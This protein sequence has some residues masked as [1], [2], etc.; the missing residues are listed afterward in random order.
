MKHRT[1][2]I[3]FIA[4]TIAA[5]AQQPQPDDAQAQQ[6]AAPNQQQ[7]PGAQQDGAEPSQQQPG[8]F[9]RR[10][11]APVDWNHN[12]EVYPNTVQQP[13]NGDPTIGKRN[14]DSAPRPSA[15]E[16]AT[17]AVNPS[18]T[19]YGGLLSQWHQQLV[20]D[21]LMSVEF[22]GLVCSL[23][24]ILFL[25]LY[26]LW[27]Q[28]QRDQRLQVTV[29]LVLQLTNSRNFARYHNLRVI[30]IHNDLVE[31]LNDQ[32]ERELREDGGAPRE[33]D[34]AT[35]PASSSLAPSG[36]DIDSTPQQQP[37]TSGSEQSQEVSSIPSVAAASE[38]GIEG[39]SQFR[40]AGFKKKS[41]VVDNGGAPTAQSD[42][43][44]ALARANAAAVGEQPAA[45]TDA[46]GEESLEVKNRRLEAQVQALQQRTTSLRN[47]LNQQRQA[48]AVGG[49][50]NSGEPQ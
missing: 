2:G 13:D 41:P 19:N 15:V 30:K 44:I 3:I 12:H 34:S 11:N 50:D 48:S 31:R 26:V 14:C 37:E 35:L 8:P 25:L 10:T 33:I 43:D 28:R 18:D 40:P 46:K 45:G 22:W 29:D 49:S 47:Q 4:A 27:L 38:F 16:S 21:L 42:V 24:T 20:H 39:N 17:H 9:D 7:I 6:Y 32:H 23:V 1:L 36:Q 5:H